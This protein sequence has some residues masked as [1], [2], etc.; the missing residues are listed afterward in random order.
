MKLTVNLDTKTAVST[1]SKLDVDGVFQC[2]VLE[3]PVPIPA[4]VYEIKLQ[5]SERFGRLMPFL[6]N[7]PG[8][9]GIEIHYGNTA[10]NTKDCLLVGQTKGENFVGNSG[11]AFTVLFAKLEKEPSNSIEIRRQVVV[12]VIVPTVFAVPVPQPQKGITMSAGWQK[13]ESFFNS[14]RGHAFVAAALAIAA[15][16]LP[17]YAA[18]LNQASITF[19]YGAVVAGAAAPKV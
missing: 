14:A 16:A 3:P 12:P 17:Q 1:I 5:H 4:G 6:Q 9:T 19:G 8:H 13:V 7:V 18:I 10:A 15:Q 2:Y 11:P